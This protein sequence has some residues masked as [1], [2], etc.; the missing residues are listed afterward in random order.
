GESNDHVVDL[1]MTLGLDGGNQWRGLLDG[2]AARA[3]G[4]ERRWILLTQSGRSPVYCMFTRCRRA[5]GVRGGVRDVPRVQRNQPWPREPP[6]R[7]PRRRRRRGRRHQQ[8]PGAPLR[9]EGEP[10]GAQLGAPDHP[11][12]V[13]QGV[14]ARR[15]GR[16][17]QRAILPRPVHGGA[18]L[19]R[20]AVRR[21]RRGAP[22]LRRAAGARRAVPLR[23]G[24]PQRGRVRGRGARGAARARGPV[25]PPH[26]P[27]GVP[28]GADQ[29]GG[30][31]AG[32][33]GRERRWRRVH[34]GGREGLPGSWLEGEAGHRR[35]VLEM[36][37]RR[38]PVAGRR[39]E[40][41]TD[42]GRK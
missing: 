12:A 30:Q 31:G 23:R 35:L 20:R 4:R 42:A 36:L 6:H 8:C 1:G 29:D 39:R 38:H 10:R 17:P 32:V 13:A 41:D 3:S 27:R 21:A 37:D 5:R 2:L 15:A 14:R 40:V 7:R 11:Q 16:R 19:L 28:V 18:A 22:A 34:G 33:A 25:A 9:G 26:E 24:D